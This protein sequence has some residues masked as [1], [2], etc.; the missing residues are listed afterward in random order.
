MNN[1]YFQG[2]EEN[3]YHISVGAAVRNQEGKICCHYFEKFLHKDATE[4]HNFYILMR[5]TIEPNETIEQTLARGL[6]EEFGMEATLNRYL[7]SLTSYFPKKDTAIEKTTL[8]FLCDFVS[9]DETKRKIDDPESHS[10]ITW[11]HPEELMI[12]MKEQGARLRRGLN[13]DESSILER[14]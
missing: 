9:I 13:L 12:K 10:A 6:M 7:G 14:L 2:K 1:N 5:E 3:P 11:I 4:L 8:Y